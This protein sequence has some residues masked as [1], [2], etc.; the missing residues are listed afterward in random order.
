MLYRL[1][2]LYLVRSKRGFNFAI[3]HSNTE[4][5]PRDGVGR[6]A[7]VASSV[8]RVNGR[9]PRPLLSTA[10]TVLETMGVVTAD[11]PTRLGVRNWSNWHVAQFVMRFALWSRAVFLPMAE[12]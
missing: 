11:G 10:A 12:R 7:A 2:D 8:A 4:V 9:T 6:G 5:T 1:T 3:A